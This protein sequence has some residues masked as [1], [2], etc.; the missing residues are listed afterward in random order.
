MIFFYFLNFPGLYLGIYSLVY[1]WEL[2]VSTVQYVQ[3]AAY[4]TAN[5]QVWRTLESS[6]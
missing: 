4:G 3:M 6:V 2:N 1:I 5:M